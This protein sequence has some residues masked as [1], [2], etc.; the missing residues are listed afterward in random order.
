MIGSEIGRYKIV[1]RLGAG[2]MGEVYRA[3]DTT[4]GRSVALKFL[5]AHL[6]NDDEARQRFLREAK[7]AAAITHPNICHV[8]EVAEEGGKTFLAMT[9]LAGESLEDRIAK[10]PLP[11]KEALDIGRQISEGLEAAHEK[12]IVHRDIKPANIMVDAKG[13]A[14]ILDFGLARLTEASKLTRQDQTVGTAAYMSPEQIQGAEVDHRTDIWALGCVLYE[15]VAGVRPFK[16]QYDQALSYEIVHE[17]PEPLTSVRTGVPVELELLIGKCLNKDSGQR[18]Q[19]A[20][21]LAVDLRSLSLQLDSGRSRVAS[22]LPGKAAPGPL[23][24]YRVIE[25]IEESQDS[26]RYLAEDLQSRRS[27]A[28]RV[29][30]KMEEERADREGRRKQL[31]LIAVAVAGG[32]LASVSVLFLLFRSAPREEKASWR[33]SIAPE[34]LLVGGVSPD[35][36]NIGYLTQE[37]SKQTLWMRPLDSETPRMLLELE[38]FGAGSWSPDGQAA[39]FAIGKDLTRIATGGGEPVALC[40]LPEGSD[41]RSY[42]SAA[43][44]PNDDEIVFASR[45]RLYEVSARGGEPNPLFA[46]E[47]G[48]PRSITGPKFLPAPADRWLL[49]THSDSNGDPMLGLLH[50]STGEYRDL[51]AGLGGTYS[52]TGHLI[53]GLPNQGVWAVP[54]SLE[55]LA[56]TGK[57][58]PIDRGGTGAFLSRDGILT[59]TVRQGLDSLQLVWKDRTGAAVG[60]AGRPYSETIVGHVS[61]SPDARFVAVN[62]TQE[63]NTD[64]WLNEV[65]RPVKTRFTYDSG[66]QSTPRWLPL[67]EAVSYSSPDPAKGTTL[68]LQAIDGGGI[69]RELLGP[70]PGV[71]RQITGWSSDGEYALYQESAAGEGGFDLWYLRRAGEDFE[72]VP[73]LDTPF[74]QFQ[75][76][77]SPDDRWV[78][79]VSDESGRN[80]VY[81][82]SFPDGADKRQISLQGGWMPR[83]AGSEIFY[84]QGQTMMAVPV[85]TQP[86]LTIGEPKPL[87]SSSELRTG[88][89]SPIYDVTADGQRFIL[90]VAPTPEEVEKET[91]KRPQ[92]AIRIL[93]NWYEQFRDREQE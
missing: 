93:G 49:T 55:E 34:N 85:S 8:Y 92:A 17:E 59:Y 48:L 87:F 13:R 30:P 35:G 73:F 21:E 27:V 79:Y 77:F 67:G 76:S 1:E 65:D 39:V 61:L 44:G 54:F 89:T 80:E 19:H 63:D 88:R 16:G 25:N 70:T 57:P 86:G 51:I 74:N 38:G 4:L 18:Y 50:R 71:G 47:S 81:L 69:A 72:P 42:G 90:P 46:D 62:A 11:L 2:G 64:I 82:R 45:G 83:W 10:G 56:V 7:A 91:G 6:L 12:G 15:M 22:S 60:K 26:A 28:I 75:A 23:A 20:D 5:A 43:W 40:E 14:T 9:Y 52:P 68:Y 41:Y 66:T 78:V 53:Y 58:F 37:G 29:V 24:R 31:L 84:I 32:V 36:K 33:F 3:E